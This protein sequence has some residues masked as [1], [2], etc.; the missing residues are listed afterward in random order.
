MDLST[1]KDL[2]IGSKPVQS[3]WLGGTKVW[4][5]KPPVDIQAI[6]DAMLLWYD[7]KRQGATNESMAE[8]PV[9][10][11]L[12]GNGHD[13]TCYN[14]GWGGMSGVGSYTNFS[15]N[16]SRVNFEILGTQ[17]W[18]IKSLKT[19]ADSADE[20]ILCVAASFNGRGKTLTIKV[21]GIPEDSPSNFLIVRNNI[22]AF[23]VELHN[24]DNIVTF[25][26]DTEGYFTFRFENV[27]AVNNITIEV[28]PEYPNAL[29]AD[30]VDD[31]VKVGGLPILTDYTVIAKRKLLSE[32][33]GT[34]RTFS[35]KGTTSYQ[36][37]FILERQTNTNKYEIYSFGQGSTPTEIPTDITYMTSNSYNGNPIAKGDGIDED[38]V[39]IFSRDDQHQCI[40][41]VLYSFILFNRTLTEEEINWVKDNLIEGTYK[42]PENLMIDAWIFS[43]HTNEEAPTQITGEKG[44]ALNCYN[45]A[46]NEEG[47]GFK[48]G[49]LCFDGVN[50]RLQIYKHLPLLKTV[51][52]KYVIPKQTYNNYECLIA[53]ADEPNKHTLLNCMDHS[54][55]KTQLGSNMSGYGYLAYNFAED[56]V[57]TDYLNTYG[58]NGEPYIKN[59][60]TEMKDTY[61]IT[62]GCIYNN[63]AYMQSKI[64]Y[65]AIYS[66]SLTDAECMTEI[67]RLDALWESRK[68]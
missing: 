67:Q 10:T 18:L 63:V 46:W 39:H 13:A 19:E 61:Q 44:T 49:F 59:D 22:S 34:Y 23:A 52:A 21:D 31:Y 12:S 62:M 60:T 38:I 45:F 28:L 25:S 3:A 47:S 16:S 5:R 41:A 48:D 37:A 4:E 17:K 24:G 1:M 9:L 33:D 58:R 15:A 54:I 6:K 7:L 26:T 35:A 20:S 40:S 27:D 55:S 42:N 68:Q 66:E 2:Y 36:G 14:F 51:I 29:V 53:F 50:D 30:G 57:H 11:D 32:L 8:N 43:G 64:A 65:A 56:E